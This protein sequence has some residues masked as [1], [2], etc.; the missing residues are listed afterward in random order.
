M[1]N[2]YEPQRSVDGM[3]KLIE[4]YNFLIKAEEG[5][6]LGEPIFLV[7][8][9]EKIWIEHKRV[10]KIKGQICPYSDQKRILEDFFKK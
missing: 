10:C 7:R 2:T 3:C 1:R 5:E 6:F 8:C 9:R 4:P